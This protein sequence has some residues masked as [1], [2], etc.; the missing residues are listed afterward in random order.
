MG[1]LRI[2]KRVSGDSRDSREGA[3]GF[4]PMLTDGSSGSALSAFVCR[5]R[6]DGLRSGGVQVK[7]NRNRGALSREAEELN[8]EEG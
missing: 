3:W 5:R 1:E 8:Q 2:E 4:I 6:I 7:M